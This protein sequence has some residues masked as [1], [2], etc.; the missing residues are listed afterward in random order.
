MT[1]IVGQ[2]LPDGD[3]ELAW[4]FVE[5][6]AKSASTFDDFVPDKGKPALG[7]TKNSADRTRT[8]HHHPHVWAAGRRQDV[9]RGSR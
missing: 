1:D 5:S 7:C 4:E 9:Y 2:V 3:K 8:R 6:K